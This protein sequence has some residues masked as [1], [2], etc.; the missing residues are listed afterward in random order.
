MLPCDCAFANIDRVFQSLPVLSTCLVQVELKC[1]SVNCCVLVCVDQISESNSHWWIETLLLP[2]NCLHEF[3]DWFA[4]LLLPFVIDVSLFQH[5]NKHFLA[6][7][8][9][10]TAEIVKS[11]NNLAVN[12]L[13][14]HPVVLD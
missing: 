4:L 14:W 1:E 9:R 6:G 3:H 5:T 13:D 2:V 11:D 8:T 7:N 12:C 10:Q